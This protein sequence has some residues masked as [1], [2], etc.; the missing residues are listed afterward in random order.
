MSFANTELLPGLGGWFR[1]LI[2]RDPY[3][4]KSVDDSQAR[5]GANFKA[6]EEHLTVNTY[7]VGERVTLAD[8]FTAAIASRGFEYFFDKE[9]RTAH[10]AVAR[11]FET[12]AHQDIYKAVA[13]EPKFIEKAIPNTPPKKEAAPKAE[14]P[15]AEPKPKAAAKEV[16]D[17]ED[18][19]PAAAP[20]PKHPIEL[21]GKSTFVLDDWYDDSS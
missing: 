15:K 16:E 5:T 12:L 1:P 7:L 17:D 18:D 11:W 3:N 4:K 10:P 2:G 19:E 14:K 9:W 6:L 20:K 8:L 13:G 21:L